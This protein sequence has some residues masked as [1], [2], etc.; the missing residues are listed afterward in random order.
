MLQIV[1]TLKIVIGM[2]A[3]VFEKIGLGLDWENDLAE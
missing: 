3:K 1:V 2:I